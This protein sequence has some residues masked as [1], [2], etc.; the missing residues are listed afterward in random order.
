MLGRYLILLGTVGYRFY[1]YFQTH[2]ISMVP[3]KSESKNPQVEWLCQ[4]L[5]D[6]AVFTT[7]SVQNEWL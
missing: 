3:I 7:E 2:R 1:Q 5:K 6:K 4:N